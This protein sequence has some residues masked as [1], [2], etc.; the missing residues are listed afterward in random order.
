MFATKGK[1]AAMAY[2]LSHPN[3]RVA[4]LNGIRPGTEDKPTLRRCRLPTAGDLRS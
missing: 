1:T 2:S 4:S 3:V